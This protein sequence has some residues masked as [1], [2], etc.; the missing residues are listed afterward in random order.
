MSIRVRMS[1]LFVITG[2]FALLSG[3]SGARAIRELETSIEIDQRNHEVEILVQRLQLTLLRSSY[4][5]TSF[6][7]GDLDARAQYAALRT[8]SHEVLDHLRN[9]GLPQEDQRRITS[10]AEELERHDL[11][12]ERAFFLAKKGEDAEAFRAVRSWIENKMV[13]TVERDVA[14]LIE[15]FRS[16]SLAAEIEAR[17]GGEAARLTILLS[18]CALVGF[19][20][21]SSILVRLWIVKPLLALRQATQEIAQGNYGARIAVR[22]KHELGRLA[23]DVEKMAESIADYQTQLVEKE[24]YAAVGEMTATVAHNIR[25]P[26]GSI[27]ALAQ[28]SRNQLA[29][30]SPVFAPLN[31]IM[32]TVDRTDRWL[33]DLLIALRPVKVERVREQLGPILEEVATAVR[34]YAAIQGVSLEVCLEEALPPVDVD[35]RKLGQALVSLLTNAVEATPAG[36][37]VRLSSQLDAARQHHAEIV[38]EDQGPGVPLAEQEKIFS[39]AFTTKVNGTG[40]GLSLCQRIVFGH[41]GHISVDSKPGTGCRMRV[42]LPISTAEEGQHGSG[43]DS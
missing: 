43:T 26:L 37:R 32:K 14:T 27:R 28:A 29:E 21:A 18:S 15:T 6:L 2:V 17:R 31:T 35:R 13:P 11:A 42:S 9:Y 22:S 38:V 40:L 34:D 41:Q 16:R 20:V 7:A 39:P 3:A 5:L 23:R 24:R 36:G 1:L 33:K 19:V 30:E 4:A 25:N 12:A 8:A 10:L